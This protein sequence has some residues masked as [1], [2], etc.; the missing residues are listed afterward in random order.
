[1][2]KQQH[3]HPSRKL[4]IFLMAIGI[5]T[6]TT[7]CEPGSPNAGASNG[8]PA[9]R[10]PATSEFKGIRIGDSITHID[11]KPVT[12]SMDFSD[13]RIEAALG[14]GPTTVTVEWED[15]SVETFEVKPSDSNGANGH[16]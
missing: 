9:S 6:C 1:M 4:G 3:H 11:G 8:Q 16:D 14:D 10:V 12:E 2:T 13:L 5:A 15:G 7:G